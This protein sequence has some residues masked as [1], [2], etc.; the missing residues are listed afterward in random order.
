MGRWLPVILGGAFLIVPV[1][2]AQEPIVLINE[3]YYDAPG[4]DT[5]N[6]WIEFLNV[7]SDSA[8]LSGWKIQR[9][10]TT[11]QTV[12]TFPSGAS[13]AGGGR[14]LVGE[15]NVSGAQ[16]TASLAFQNGGGAT[17][18][19]RLTTGEGD[20]VDVLLYDQPNANG[21]PDQ[22][23]S[24]GSSFAPAAPEGSSLARL[25]DGAR[26]SGDSRDFSVTSMLTPGGP[27]AAGSAVPTT[28]SAAP[29][30][31]VSSSTG[32][33]ADAVVVNEILPNPVG[34]DEEGEFLEL[35][36]SGTATAQLSGYKVD[37]AEG[38]STP[39][40]IPNST[41][42]APKAYLLFRR[43]ETKLA[44]NN[45]ADRGRLLRPDGSLV[46]ELVYDSVPKG[47]GASVARRADGTAAWTSAPTPGGENAFQS[48]SVTTAPASASAAPA[49]PKYTARSSASPRASVS[50]S[51]TSS[52]TGRVRGTTT[53]AEVP[54]S[55]S[56]ARASASSNRQNVQT[57]TE[58]ENDT[59]PETIALSDLRSHG[60]GTKVTT[61]GVVSVPPGVLDP[62][63]FYL[64]GSG[65]GV[66][67]ADGQFPELTIGD[68]V[69]VTGTL[70]EPR[71]ERLL[72]VAS[73]EGI[74]K[75]E[76]G[77]PPGP[78]EVKTGDIG[79]SWEGSLVRVE[80]TVADTSD[81]Q[82]TLNNGSGSVRVRRVGKVEWNIADVRKNTSVRVVGIVS[83]SEGG[84]RVLPRSPDDIQ[85]E[86]SS[87]PSQPLWKRPGIIATG[88][89]VLAVAAFFSRKRGASTAR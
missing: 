59:D 52:S 27:N 80:G 26:G 87:P 57:T 68:V 89:L 24:P 1:A 5:G 58:T 45:D 85:L 67:L 6:E 30:P 8:D 3:L 75:K 17:D 73:Q 71:K 4:S 35:W 25:P 69:A 54:G 23:G 13:I 36:N 22:G 74:V 70:A 65:I 84:F 34:R 31:T 21:L 81:R 29:S 78:H 38:G 61:E 9:G 86:S 60:I 39:Y 33:T 82:F 83:E 43:P 88:I 44:F 51:T 66:V 18:G 28:A 77:A 11:F 55:P 62:Y 49:S 48:V 2:V 19:V 37:D 56:T 47:E 15:Q 10:G 76:S 41:T 7:D 50:P 12:F 40:V 14:I 32:G 63:L 20:V 53:V 72:A 79:E 16:F 42:L 46:H 64:A